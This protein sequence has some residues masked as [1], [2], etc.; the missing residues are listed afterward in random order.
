MVLQQTNISGCFKLQF[1]TFY[2]HRGSFLKSFQSSQFQNQGINFEIK[3]SF[4]SISNQGVIR[5]FHFQLPPFDHDKIIVC[6]A[7]KVFDAVLDL[8]TKSSTL[9]SFSGFELDSRLSEGIFIPRGCAHAFQALEKCSSLL[10]FLNGEYSA[11]HD[12]GIQWNS[13][14]NFRWPLQNPILSKRDL[15]FPNLQDF[16]SPF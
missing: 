8:R 13:V 5:G 2:D 3:E 15:S 12:M 9:N 1:N 4:Y 11:A 6:V 16:R 10:Y 14:A 7:G